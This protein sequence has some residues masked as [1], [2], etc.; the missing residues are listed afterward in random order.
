MLC[1]IDTSWEAFV[2][3]TCKIVGLLDGQ[4]EHQCKGRATELCLQA[5]AKTKTEYICLSLQ[6]KW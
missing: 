5:V 4:V 3:K 1:H 2:G 6:I